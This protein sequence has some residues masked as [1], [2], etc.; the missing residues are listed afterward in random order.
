MLRRQS[1]VDAG[2]SF[3]AG[4]RHLRRVRPVLPRASLRQTL[5]PPVA[6]RK[7]RLGLGA[8]RLS[9][10]APDPAVIENGLGYP[11][12]RPTQRFW[13]LVLPANVRWPELESPFCA[14]CLLVNLNDSA[15]D[16]CV[17]KVG[18]ATHRVASRLGSILTVAAQYPKVDLELVSPTGRYCHCVL[19]RY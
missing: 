10:R 11:G 15:V 9:C 4:S 17:F 3:S 6:R 14:G 1:C 18:I 8:R 7:K 2:G 19:W 5:C 13:S 16:E 12:R